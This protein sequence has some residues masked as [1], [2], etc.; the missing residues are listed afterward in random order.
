MK[1]EIFLHA[2]LSIGVDHRRVEPLHAAPHDAVEDLTDLFL[3]RVEPVLHGSAHRGQL[4]R[5]SKDFGLTVAG[6]GGDGRRLDHLREPLRGLLQRV[7]LPEQAGGGAAVLAPALVGDAFLER[8]EGR[9]PGERGPRGR[10]WEVVHRLLHRGG[11]IGAG[12][13]GN[14]GPRGEV[15]QGGHRVGGGRHLVVR[16]RRGGQAGAD[17]LQLPC[18]GP[19]AGHAPRER[20]EVGRGG[21][22]ARAAAEGAVAAGREERG[23]VVHEEEG[24]EVRERL[25][26]AAEL[27]LADRPRRA[28]HGRRGAGEPRPPPD[29]T[30]PIPRGF[31]HVEGPHRALPELGHRLLRDEGAA[32]AP[33]KE[34]L[35]A[36]EERAQQ[37]PDPR[38][39]QELRIVPVEEAREARGEAALERVEVGH[40]RRR[41]GVGGGWGVA[42]EGEE[43]AAEGGE[44]GVGVGGRSLVVRRR[45]SGGRR[46]SRARV[47][48][49]E[50]R[51]GGGWRCVPCVYISGYCTT[52]LYDFFSGS[53]LRYS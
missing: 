25:P 23:G 35:V 15:Q 52:R 5:S 29:L 40:V 31:A 7:G 45:H 6:E 8:E 30:H 1:G 11:A 26:R 13:G 51:G 34:L 21:R 37:A 38:G 36:R 53:G 39:R 43:G 32:A 48:E 17:G 28:E 49:G 27:A 42:V 22:A 44:R 9:R 12:N 18:R 46:R 19:R 20:A 4:G 41:R 50:E 10:G 33:R 14:E 24:G 47:E 3:E 2:G 16:A